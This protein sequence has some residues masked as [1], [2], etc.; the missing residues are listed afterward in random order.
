MQ[1]IDVLNI[2]QQTTTIIHHKLMDMKKIILLAIAT[3][4]VLLGLYTG[5]KK[6]SSIGASQ[7]QW[8]TLTADSVRYNTVTHLFTPTGNIKGALQSKA[9]IEQIYYYLTTVASPDQLVY[10]DTSFVQGSS[11]VDFEIPESVFKGL[12]LEDATGIKVM[13]RLLNNAAFSGDI[14]IV[15]FTPPLP[16]LSGFTDTLQPDLTGGTTPVKGRITA[17]SG[18]TKILIEDD[19]TG[20]YTGVDSILDLKGATNY[21]LDYDYTYRAQASHVRITAFDTYGLSKSVTIFMPVLTYDSYKDIQMSA[22]GTSSTSSSNCFF[23]TDGAV[24][25]SCAIEGQEKDLKFLLYCSGSQVLSFYSPSN[26]T[27]VA[28]NYKC[29][30][31][32]WVQQVADLKDVKFR[33][34]IPGTKATDAVYAAYNSNQMATLDDSFFEGIAAPGS[35]SAKYDTD[36]GNASSN[37]FNLTKAYLIWAQVPEADGST[38]NILIRV[39]SVNI[40]TD[41][42]AQGLSS[43]VMDVMMEK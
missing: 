1:A 6:D 18:L 24:I 27:G 15:P 29:D 40:V 5:C 4:T 19:A 2:C 38:K 13:V 21:Q 10:I 12:D 9:P 20:T 36:E 35:H 11:K 3:A 8:G 23:M 25:G 41:T 33:V 17:E 39:K 16:E 26:S 34:L 42:G 37:V 31:V 22:Q 43:M 30:G 28:K 7:K 14:G 32:S